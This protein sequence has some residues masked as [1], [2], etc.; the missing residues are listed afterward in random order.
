MA[1]RCPQSPS[2]SPRPASPLPGAS[3]QVK[4]SGLKWR[5]AFTVSIDGATL[6]TGK[7]PLF[8]AATATISLGGRRGLQD[9][10]RHWL[11][12]EPYRQLLGRPIAKDG[13][14]ASLTKRI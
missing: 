5:E 6:A 1:S 7:A 10:R 14:A 11:G 4:V 3:I 13:G 9:H 2:R 8:F 12:R